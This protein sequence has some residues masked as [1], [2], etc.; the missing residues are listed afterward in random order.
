MRARKKKWAENEILENEL[1]LHEAKDTDGNWEQI[2]ANPHP[3]A[4]EIGCGMGNFIVDMAK[5]NQNTN[6]IG[7]EREKMVIVAGARKVREWNEAASGEQGDEALKNVRFILG[8]AETLEELI[9]AGEL[10]RIYINFCDPWM[11]KKKWA[12][13][14]L[15]HKNFLN[16]YKRLLNEN[17]EL[18]LKTDSKEL[19]EFSANE[20]V[21][22]GW[23]LKNL[24]LDLHNSQWAK[25]NVMTEYEKKFSEQGMVI[26]RL[27]A[28]VEDKSQ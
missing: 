14:R 19:F 18:Q 17:G 23:K 9:G 12:K 4:L 21:E 24:T 11:R 7:L 22:C 6:F 3:L 25:G 26:Y 13:R 5:I 20:F 27:V 1:I 16:M 10:S 28:G 8:D 15:T 2:F